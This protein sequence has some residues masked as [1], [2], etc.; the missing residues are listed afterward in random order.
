[1]KRKNTLQQRKD[2]NPHRKKREI[3]DKRILVVR[4]KR[5]RKRDIESKCLQK[6]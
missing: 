2:Q 4:I 5:E 3:S 6:T 1:M